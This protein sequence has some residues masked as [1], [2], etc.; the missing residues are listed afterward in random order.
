[1]G[2]V[3]TMRRHDHLVGIF[4][5]RTRPAAASAQDIRDSLLN[6]IVVQDLLPGARLGEEMLVEVFNLGRRHV[7][8]ALN[9][10]AW[11]GL[12]THVPNRGAR[13]ATP[14]ATEAREI[15]AAR[16]AIE[17]GIVEALARTKPPPD[18][19][20][21]EAALA[22]ERAERT[23]GRLR[24]AIRLSGGFHVL[25]A[26]LSGNRILAGQVELL[27]ARTSLL[28]ALFENPGA[29]TCWH[30]DHRAIID[31]IR[32]RK[33][34]PAVALMQRHLQELLKGIDLTRQAIKEFDA[35]EV[36]KGK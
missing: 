25:L 29:L 31:L 22:Q 35:R 30:D 4:N 3:R 10:L 9:Q 27:V 33:P 32:L 15:F 13:V 8:A 28:V 24:E 6:A 18:Y 17:S 2:G 12:V 1:M 7:S 16:H 11:E 21:I 26:R 34:R 23:Q 5:S 14:N 19:T 20:V 36:F